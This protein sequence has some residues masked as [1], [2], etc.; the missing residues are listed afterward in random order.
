MRKPV[1]LDGL[2]NMIQTLSE[3]S[4]EFSKSAG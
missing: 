1:K 2:D 3:M 4:M